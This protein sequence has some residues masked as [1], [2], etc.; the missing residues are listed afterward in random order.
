MLNEAVCSP[1][2]VSIQTGKGVSLKQWFPKPAA[3]LKT[4]KSQEEPQLLLL[5]YKVSELLRR[6]RRSPDKEEKR[7]QERRGL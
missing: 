3:H 2:F 6:D 7:E 1:R 4:L 5:V